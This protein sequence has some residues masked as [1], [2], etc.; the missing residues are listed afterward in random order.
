MAEQIVTLSIL[1]AGRSERADVAAIRL[2]RL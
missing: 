1:H 2:V